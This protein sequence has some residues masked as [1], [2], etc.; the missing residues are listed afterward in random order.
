MQHKAQDTTLMRHPRAIRRRIRRKPRVTRDKRRG[1]TSYRASVSIG[2]YTFPPAPT[3][4]LPDRARTASRLRH[5][6]YHTE[7]AYAAWVR[8]FCLFHRGGDGRPR[9]PETRAEAEGAAFLRGGLGVASRL[10]A[11]DEG[12]WTRGVEREPRP[13][14]SAVRR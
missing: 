10:D 2:L 8:C 4:K 7:R 12:R 6:S 3:P 5:R 13:R 9:H 11:L 14:G 1:V